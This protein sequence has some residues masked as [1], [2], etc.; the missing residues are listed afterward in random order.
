MKNMLLAQ[1]GGPSAAIN[2]TIAGAVERVLTSGQVDRIYGAV[3]G[4][5]GVFEERFVDLR[6]PLSSPQQIKR[7]CHTPAAAL[8][9]CRMKLRADDESLFERLI[10]V[11]R[12]YEISYFIYIGGNDSMDTVCKL[13]HYLKEKG[14][15]DIFV[16]GAP[17]TIDNDL[18]HTDHCPGYGSAAKYIAATFAELRCDCNVYDV[19]AV[20]IVEVMGRN[21]GWL[22]AASALSRLGGGEGPDAIYLC[23]TVFDPEQFL[24]DIKERLQKKDALLIAVSEGLRD[25]N[26]SYIC[27]L[28]GSSGCDVFGHTQLSGTA[29]CLEYLVRERIGCK[30]RSIEL[31]LMQRCA[32]HL[33]SATDLYESR[34]LGMTAADRCLCGESGRMAVVERVSDEPYRVRYGSA[35]LSGIA[36]E[37]KKIPLEWI[38]PQGNDI[39]EPLLTYMK[40]LILGEEPIEYC[41]GVPVHGAPYDAGDY[42]T[43]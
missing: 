23:E 7:L 31:S 2:A 14:I 8:G 12:K 20:T 43:R 11:F 38:A 30:V 13:S 26:G 32:S 36:N 15:D 1:S 19:P 34:M 37:E 3:N 41:G 4:I 10:A 27:E 42:F 24:C 25:K 28:S 33:A 35:D 16:M 40:P 18:M 17:K 22:T 9:S 39:L 6:E 29:K 5:K 21:A